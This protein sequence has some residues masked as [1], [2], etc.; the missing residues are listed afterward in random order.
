MKLLDFDNFVEF[1][2]RISKSVFFMDEKSAKKATV[3]AKKQ[4]LE[5]A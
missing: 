4:L 5:T 3:G 1:L 2:L